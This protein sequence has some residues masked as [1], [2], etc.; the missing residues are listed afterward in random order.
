MD[1][2]MVTILFC[3]I[4]LIILFALALHSFKVVGEI[5]LKEINSGLCNNCSKQLKQMKKTHNKLEKQNAKRTKKP[6]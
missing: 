3:I 6:S 4:G 2:F 1:S 5:T